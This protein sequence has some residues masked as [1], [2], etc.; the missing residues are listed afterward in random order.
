MADRTSFTGDGSA[1][2]RPGALKTC[3]TLK[4]SRAFVT[5][6]FSPLPHPHWANISV[7]LDAQGK[8]LIPN[9]F[10]IDLSY[11]CICGYCKPLNPCPRDLIH[12]MI[13][14]TLAPTS[15]PPD[16]SLLGLTH[17]IQWAPSHPVSHVPAF[18][19]LASSFQTPLAFSSLK[20][21]CVFQSKPSFPFIPVYLGLLGWA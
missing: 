17:P 5:Q 4:S 6:G 19:A 14:T 21:D 3:Y 2:Q 8:K 13:V 10:R 9:C 20:T 16:S 7:S 18:P 15:T 12:D 11:F 1:A